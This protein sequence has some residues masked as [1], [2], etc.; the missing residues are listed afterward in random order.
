MPR[1]IGLSFPHAREPLCPCGSESGSAASVRIR[2]WRETTMPATIPNADLRQDK[3][4]PVDPLVD[5]RIHDS[6]DA[7]QQAGPQQRRGEAAQK[8]WPLRKHRQH[9]S[10]E[11]AHQQ[12][13]QQVNGTAMRRTLQMECSDL[14]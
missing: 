14:A 11:Q 6:E 3:P 12:R 9:H 10:I 7:V 4:E 13:D 5:H 2:S 8:D 1:F